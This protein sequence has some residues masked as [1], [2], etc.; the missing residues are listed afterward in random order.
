MAGAGVESTV[1]LYVT[2]IANDEYVVFSLTAL[3]CI[4]IQH[5]FIVLQHPWTPLQ[6]VALFPE[7][8]HI[9]RLHFGRKRIISTQCWHLFIHSNHI[10]HRLCDDAKHATVLSWTGPHSSENNLSR[11]IHHQFRFKVTKIKLFLQDAENALRHYKGYTGTNNNQPEDY[12]IH[13]EFKRLKSITNERKHMD[14]FSTADLCKFPT[15]IMNASSASSYFNFLIKMRL[16]LP[17][18]TAPE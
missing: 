1:L 8:W 16:I 3:K 9:V 13:K 2:E 14:S 7:C 18:F 5:L 11:Q 15:K 10:C 17:F 4:L 12:A 6:L